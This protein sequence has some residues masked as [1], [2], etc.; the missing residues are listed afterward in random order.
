MSIREPD[1]RGGEKKIVSLT[2]LK[3]RR[4]RLIFE[5][6]EKK[7]VSESTYTS[8]FLYPG[9][10]LTP[11][12]FEE[13]EKRESEAEVDS[14]V[15]SLLSRRD[16]APREVIDKLIRVK[17]MSWKEASLAVD[18][19]IRSGVLNPQLFAEN[20]AQELRQ[21]GY[22]DIAIKNRLAQKGISENMIRDVLSGE[23]AEPDTAEIE[24]ICRSHPSDSNLALRR[25]I[26]AKLSAKGFSSEECRSALERFEASHP[27][28]F[29]SER[30]SEALAEQMRR[31]GNIDDEKKIRKLAAA[32]FAV[33]DIRQALKEGEKK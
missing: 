4:I 16:Y 5:S 33:S 32:G 30:E 9:K 31:V 26:T 13:L 7:D 20:Y 11:S 21:K 27:E 24:K 17:G 18:R 14:Y 1:A 23:R 29:S 19:F 28:F 2:R 3:N 22:G 6:G 8:F 10:K 12:E 25:R 15:E